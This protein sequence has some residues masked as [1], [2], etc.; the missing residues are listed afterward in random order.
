MPFTQ[1]A[2]ER[3][4]MIGW[5]KVNWKIPHFSKIEALANE[6]EKPTFKEF[7]NAHHGNK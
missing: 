1:N 7:P 5:R 2:I 4:V 6:G 3:N